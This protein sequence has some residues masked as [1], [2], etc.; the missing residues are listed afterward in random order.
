M[1][2]KQKIERKDVPPVWGSEF[3]MKVASQGEIQQNLF[4]G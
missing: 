1:S 2:P 3:T 4:L